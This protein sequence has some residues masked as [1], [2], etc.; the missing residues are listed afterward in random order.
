MQVPVFFLPQFCKS[1]A[2][3]HL[4]TFSTKW[5]GWD[6]QHSFWVQTHISVCQPTLPTLGQSHKV[7]R[8]QKNEVCGCHQ[9]V[10][11][12]VHCEWFTQRKNRN[13]Q[14]VHLLKGRTETAKQFIYS[15]EEQKRPSS[16]FTGMSLGKT[17]TFAV[18]K[19]LVHHPTSLLAWVTLWQFLTV[20]FS[21]SWEIQSFLHVSF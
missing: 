1:K 16:S 4:S 20:M 6:R 9:Q 8:Q 13:G 11:N 19:Q 3:R 7:H 18:S 17:R 10:V 21:L 15:K 12:Q 2:P 14:A 5:S